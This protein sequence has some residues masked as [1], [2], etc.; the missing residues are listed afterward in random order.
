M[1]VV[2]RMSYDWPFE[3]SVFTDRVRRLREDMAQHGFGALIVTEPSDI[4]RLTGYDTQ[5][6]WNHQALLVLHEDPLR[7]V[8]FVEEV[9]HAEARAVVPVGY[10]FGEDP[11]VKIVKLLRSGDVDGAIGIDAMSRYLAVD[12]YLRLRDE[13]PGVELVN[14]SGLLEAQRLI[15]SPDEVAYL[16]E[17]LRISNEVLRDSIDNL[18]IGVL[19]RAIAAQMSFDAIALGS[20]YFTQSPYVRFGPSMVEGHLTWQGRKLAPGD[21]VELEIAAVIRRYTAPVVRFAVADRIQ[22]RYREAAEVSLDGIQRARKAMRPGARGSDVWGDAYAAADGTGL[23]YLPGGYSVG[24]GYPPDWTESDLITATSRRELRAGMVIHMVSFCQLTTAR[25]G[26]GD[27][28]L[29]TDDGCT[30]LAPF[31]MGPGPFE[32]S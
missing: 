20:D 10:R 13:L 30:S 27:V 16:T 18:G 14:A 8:C 6:Y 29:I 21:A 31:P 25:V 12:A 32:V 4:Y 11:V 26:T 19:D 1:R 28:I 24:V 7:L 15:K 3:R 17:A 9:G 22:G 2:E 23:Y 5:G